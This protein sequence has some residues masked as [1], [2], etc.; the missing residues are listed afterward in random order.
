MLKGAASTYQALS[1]D[2]ADVPEYRHSLA[3]AYM[4]LGGLY[5]NNLRQAE[6]AEAAGQQAMQIDEKLSQEHPDALEYAYDLGHCYSLLS[7]VAETA[8]RSDTA[9]I[10]IEKAIEILEDVVGRGYSQARNDLINARVQWALVLAGRG[11]Y[12]R[13]TDEAIAVARPENLSLANLYNITCVFAKSAAAAESDTKLSPPDRNRL[14]MRCADRAVDFLRQA[15]AK[16]FQSAAALKSDPDL[17]PL[18]SR[19]DF[20]KLVQE[21]EKKS[22]K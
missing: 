3:R 11:D 21:V 10:R 14:K 22:R 16:G 12:A 18:R 17:A 2:Y 4:A 13:A 6:K 8:G 20:Q 7:N 9:L 15:V 5:F 1:H 19:P